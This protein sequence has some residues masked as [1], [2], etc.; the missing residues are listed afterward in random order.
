MPLK[1]C[2]IN[3]K[4]GWKWG[5]TGKCYTGPDAK[6]KAIK[7]AL[8]ISNSVQDAPESVANFQQILESIKPKIK[9]A[10]TVQTEPIGLVVKYDVELRKIMKK[11]TA[12]TNE[13]IKTKIPEWRKEQGFIEEGL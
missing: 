10:K 6:K 13:Q 4:T 3:N 8:A 11:F 9:K 2:K 12:I 7:Q 1:K 5:N